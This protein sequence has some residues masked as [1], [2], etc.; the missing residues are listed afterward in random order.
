MKKKEQKQAMATG[1]E[2]RQRLRTWLT[3]SWVRSAGSRDILATPLVESF[4]A[5]AL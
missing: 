4:P 1:M 2:H 5:K 3:V